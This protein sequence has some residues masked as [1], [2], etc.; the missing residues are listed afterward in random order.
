MFCVP[1][2]MAAVFGRPRPEDAGFTTRLNFRFLLTVI[3]VADA[4]LAVRGQGH[5][6]RDGVGAGQRIGQEQS[7][8]LA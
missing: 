5:L 8:N 4:L 7:Q 3:V 1:S 2:V 6:E